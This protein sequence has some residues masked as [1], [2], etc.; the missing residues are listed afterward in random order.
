MNSKLK[1]TILAICCASA[2]IGCS[3]ALAACG[4]DD[5]ANGAA[6]GPISELFGGFENS[7]SIS[8]AFTN[9]EELL[10]GYNQHA[11]PYIY[12]SD[13]YPLNTIVGESIGGVRYNVYQKLRLKRDY[14]YEYTLEI[15][16]RVVGDSNINLCKLEA[17][18][19]GT[20]TY[21]VDSGEKYI[22]SVSDPTSGSE[23]RYGAFITGENNIF[24]WK[25]SSTANYT[26][27]V[28]RALK[29]ATGD[30][31]PLDRYIMG[32]SV[33]VEKDGTE[34]IL[35]NDVFYAD[36]MNDIAPY[37]S[38]DSSSVPKDEKPDTPI[39]P[40]APPTKAESDGGVTL[41]FVQKSGCG[42][43]MRFSDFNYVVVK[44]S[45][46]TVA[47]ATI[48]GAEIVGK[49][50]GDECEFEFPISY[51]KLGDA[52]DI[53]VGGTDFT[54]TPV[55]YLKEIYP[56]MPKG[57]EQMSEAYFIANIINV[58]TVFGADGAALTDGMKTQIYDAGRNVYQS[59]WDKRD[60]MDI[61]DTSDKTDDFDWVS[62]ALG[63]NKTPGLT[64]ENGVPVLAFMY[65]LNPNSHGMITATV[66]IGS[67][68]AVGATITQETFNGESVYVVK[69][70]AYAPAAFA[71]AV[72]VEIYDSGNLMSVA[73]YS[74][75]RA[76]AATYLNN[77]TELKTQSDALWSLGKAVAWYA[78]KDSAPYAYNFS[79]GSY[80]FE[81]GEYGYSTGATNPDYGF[82]FGTRI[83]V[84]GKIVDDNSGE[85]S[86]EGKTFTASRGAASNGK[87]P[88]N[89]T[90]DGAGIDGISV[91]DT[92]GNHGSITI[93]V[94]SDSTLNSMLIFNNIVGTINVGCDVVIRGTA[95]ATLTVI[96]NIYTSGKLTVDG[97]AVK[98]VTYGLYD[99]VT[100]GELEISNGG[101]LFVAYEGGVVN[102]KYGVSLAGNAVIDGTLE[103]NGFDVGVYLGDDT[104]E[105]TFTVNG[106]E[107]NIEALR[108]GINVKDVYDDPTSNVNNYL[109]RELVFDGGVTKIKVGENGVGGVSMCNITLN[110]DAELYIDVLHGEGFL[111]KF[112]SFWSEWTGYVQHSSLP[113]KIM[114]N[115]GDERVGVLS[116][117]VRGGGKIGTVG[118]M[119]LNGGNVYLYSE[120]G[121]GN[122]HTSNGA[123][124]TIA[125]CDATFENGNG[126]AAGRAIKAESGDEVITVENSSKVVFKNCD[127]AIACWG[128]A[129]G[130]YAKLINNGLI[131]LDTYKLSLEPPP[132][133][134]WQI[135]LQVENYGQIRYTNQL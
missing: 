16:V 97:V 42:V 127:V 43:A 111:G 60:N 2:F 96:G 48:G 49:V 31:S 93:D 73:T 102:T 66:K 10:G 119:I 14:T 6:K 8:V 115:S 75:T 79:N 68:E 110:G 56:D 113:V 70:P 38:Y 65:K 72:G 45:D 17:N 78:E 27:D 61:V 108:Y 34:R 90:L 87:Y 105:Q 109:S 117:I 26:L 132:W 134:N 19:K 123:V 89:I 94:K 85:V 84:G 131:I 133:D 28:E 44:T 121:S 57:V 114:T 47:S 81:L 51:D 37:C 126:I 35:Y 76:F 129:S 130:E 120:D 50:V 101:G 67:G 63:R 122:I 36:F 5:S 118:E 99:G 41:P 1:K 82:L 32:R 7:E 77:G 59:S 29:N 106:G 135:Q 91:A 83:Y 92:D 21:M 100:C 103:I 53:N 25:M 98:I 64:T 71:D 88:F 62:G 125:N 54:F 52:L 55:D 22:V 33:A 40:P 80:S 3:A 39:E 18:T 128:A 46:K 124:I 4:D 12:T 30:E 20:F 24:S 69:V 104:A 74:V 15:M 9:D 95:G 23:R 116:I 13:V 58:A 107:V 112:E 86:D 11:E